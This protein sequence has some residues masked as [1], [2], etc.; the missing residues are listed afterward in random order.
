MMQRDCIERCGRL[1]TG[2]RCAECETKRRQPYRAKAYQA[3]PLVGS[4]AL[5]GRTD[6]LT[7]DHIVPLSRG[8]TNARSN[9][10][11]LCRPCNSAKRAR[12]GDPKKSEGVGSAQ[13]PP[14]SAREKA[15]HATPRRPYRTGDGYLS[16]QAPGPSIVCTECRQRKPLDAFRRLPT[17]SIASH[18]RPCHAARNR[19]WRLE[20]G[21]EVNAR[22]RAQYAAARATAPEPGGGALR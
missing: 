8:G 9:L 10:R 15:S 16:R 11:I 12:M 19:A 4:C 17:G 22:R 5:C 20:H 7:R 14:S 6:D 2:T 21:A 1:T 18:C 13:Y 3:V